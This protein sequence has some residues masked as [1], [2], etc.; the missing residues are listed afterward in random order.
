MLHILILSYQRE[1]DKLIVFPAQNIAN[2]AIASYNIAKSEERMEMILM[3]L[4]ELR[5]MTSQLRYPVTAESRGELQQILREMGAAPS[6]MPDFDAFDG[7][8]EAAYE[9]L[10]NGRGAG[11]RLRWYAGTDGGSVSEDDIRSA[12]KDA[13]EDA[14]GDKLD[15]V[16]GIDKGKI[17]SAAASA[18]AS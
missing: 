8:D 2:P 1:R 14:I 5:K 3:K 16:E 15:D 11:Q 18:A 10:M 13:V 7:Q 6:I 12:V 4:D 9:V 17:I